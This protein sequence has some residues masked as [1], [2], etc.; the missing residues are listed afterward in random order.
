MNKNKKE[1]TET[2]YILELLKCLHFWSTKFVYEYKDSQKIS[3]QNTMQL[4]SQNWA[5]QIDQH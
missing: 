4:K 2:I 5:Q 1:H 3:W